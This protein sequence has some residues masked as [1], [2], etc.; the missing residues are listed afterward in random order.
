MGRPVYLVRARS[1]P[2]TC[3]VN[4]AHLGSQGVCGRA[5]AEGR[6]CAA[7]VCADHLCQYRRSNGHR[8]KN[9]PL[10]LVQGVMYT[11]A[12]WFPSTSAS[13]N[14][15]RHENHN[16]IGFANDD[17]TV[18]CSGTKVPGRDHCSAHA[19]ALCRWKHRDGRFCAQDAL[20]GSRYCR[21]IAGM[22][23]YAPFI[24]EEAHTAS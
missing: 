2:A 7:P 19:A 14:C 9:T 17:G 24:F 5:A 6:E 12:G 1:P 21:A 13:A 10:R 16:C 8:C 11:A 22:L 3:V 18:R 20:Q 15:A 4:D 23:S